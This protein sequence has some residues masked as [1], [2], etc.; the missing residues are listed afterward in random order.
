[1]LVVGLEDLPQVVTVI[2]LVSHEIAVVLIAFDKPIEPRHGNRRTA[3]LPGLVDQDAHRQPVIQH[4][5][6]DFSDPLLKRIR[7]DLLQL[8]GLGQN[9]PVG[10]QPVQWRFLHEQTRQAT[11]DVS[12][13][14]HF[15]TRAAGGA[16][17]VTS[18]TASAFFKR[19][20]M[21]LRAAGEVIT[22]DSN[23]SKDILAFSFGGFSFSGGL[24]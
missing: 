11:H 16:G 2:Q 12:H 19:S 4:V 7:F 14:G 15:L 24:P 13:V 21:N 17:L 8:L 18:A 23:S 10:P 20:L 3:L 1:M 22:S 5:F 9:P 6:G